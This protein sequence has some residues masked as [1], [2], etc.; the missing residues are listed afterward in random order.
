MGINKQ[1][2]DIVGKT[3]EEATKILETEGYTV[4]IAS[5]NGENHTLTCDHLVYRANLSLVDG[6]VTHAFAG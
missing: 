2:L 4:R 6:K 5:V 3:L 1:F